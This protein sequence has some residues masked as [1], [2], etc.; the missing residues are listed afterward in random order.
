MDLLSFALYGFIK[1]KYNCL[2]KRPGIWGGLPSVWVFG[3]NHQELRKARWKIETTNWTQH[4]SSTSLDSESAQQL[5]GPIDFGKQFIRIWK[6]IDRNYPVLMTIFHL[7]LLD[8][9]V[10]KIFSFAQKYFIGTSE[11]KNLKIFYQ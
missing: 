7:F 2:H 4:L 10:Q 9:K 5:V 6:F 8:L 11:C 1:Y 3:E